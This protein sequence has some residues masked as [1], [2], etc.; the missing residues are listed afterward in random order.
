MLPNRVKCMHSIILLGLFY[1][2]FFSIS[3]TTEIDRD[4]GDLYGF[5]PISPSNSFKPD[6]QTGEIWSEACLTLQISTA[7]NQAHNS[8]SGKDI[9]T[10]YRLRQI[11][12]QCCCNYTRSRS[13]SKLQLTPDH[14]T[15]LKHY[16][17]SAKGDN[18]DKEQEQWE[19]TLLIWIKQCRISTTKLCQY[20]ILKIQLL[21]EQKS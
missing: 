1:R 3:K 8:Y 14:R 10:S 13:N 5:F 12:Q 17:I 20:W 16:V 21:G 7:G 11:L 6:R 4:R 19:R 9:L 18:M 2:S 15:M